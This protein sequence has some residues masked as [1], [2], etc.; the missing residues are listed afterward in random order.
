MFQVAQYGERAGVGLKLGSSKSSQ[1][2]N[3][4]ARAVAAVHKVV[5]GERADKVEVWLNRRLMGAW[6]GGEQRGRI[7]GRGGV[8][9]RDG[10]VG[11]RAL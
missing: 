9:G 5:V 11:T 3:G 1:H 2:A 8:V 7:G 6:A 4:L 10:V